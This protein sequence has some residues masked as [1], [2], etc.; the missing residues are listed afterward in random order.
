M[1]SLTSSAAWQVVLE[2]H[3]SSTI[4]PL[5]H[6]GVAVAPDG[7]WDSARAAD[8]ATAAMLDALL[9]IA[10]VKTGYVVAQIGQSLDGCIA[11]ASGDSHYVTGLASRTHLHRLRALV[12]AVVVGVGTVARDDPALTVRHV[13]GK[14]PARVVLDPHARAPRSARVF[15]DGCAPTWHAVRQPGRAAPG[16][17]PLPLL[18]GDPVQTVAGLLDALAQRGLRRVL[19]EGG[20][21]TVSHCLAARRVD[22]LHVVVAPLLI[23][24]GRRAF[25]WPHASTLGEALRPVWRSWAL[26]D[27]RLYELDLRRSMTPAS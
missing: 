14:N 2:V 19:V 9:P 4:E 22:R 20:G 26:D 12:D 16:A 13:P 17:L 5:V 21:I 8:A 6:G 24:A 7:C 18:P 11:T 10:R 27:D 15:R 1:S 23:G 25:V 3:R